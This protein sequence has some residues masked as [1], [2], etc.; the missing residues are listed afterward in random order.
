MPAQIEV[1]AFE[2]AN[3]VEQTW[4]TQ[5]IEEAHA[6]ARRYRYRIIAHVY[7]WA[8]SEVVEDYTPG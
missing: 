8:D 7:E 1:Y 6:H 5:S 4:T 3:G 2:D